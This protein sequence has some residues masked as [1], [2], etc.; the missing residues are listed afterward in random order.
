MAV[1]SIEYVVL[2][3]GPVE[4]KSN[5]L[6]LCFHKSHVILRPFTP[7]VHYFFLSRNGKPQ[8]MATVS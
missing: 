6:L 2:F 5:D 7:G 8:Y 4:V 1:A 3:S